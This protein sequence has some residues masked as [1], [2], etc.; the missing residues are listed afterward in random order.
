MSMFGIDN[1]PADWEPP[2]CVHGHII[3]GCPDED[4]EE[5][6]T[7][8]AAQRQVHDEYDRQLRENAR[9][10]VRDMLGLPR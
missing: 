1:P 10:V 8:V 5:Q 9:K 6:N 3:L 7:F 4:C 2:H